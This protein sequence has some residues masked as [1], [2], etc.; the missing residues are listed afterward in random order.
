MTKRRAIQLVAGLCACAALALPASASAGLQTRVVGG[1]IAPAG[2]YPW[3]AAVM[4]DSAFGDTDYE[5]QFCGGV[6]VT[7]RIVLTA[8]HCVSDTDPDATH[9][10]GD[11]ILP[12]VGDPNGCFLDPNDA[13]VA[14]N[15]STLSAANGERHDIQAVFIHPDNNPSLYTDDV[16]YLV[17]S[18]AT[19]IPPLKLAGPS[20]TALWTPGRATQVTGYGTTAVGGGGAGSNNLKVA[21]VPILSDSTCSASYGSVFFAF[22]MV[23]AGYV[24]Q[25]V[26]DSCQGDSGGPLAAPAEGGIF[27]LVGLVSFGEGCANANKPGVYSRLGAGAPGTLFQGVVNAVADVESSQGIPHYDIVGSG[28]VPPGTKAPTSAKKKKCSKLKGKTKKATRKKRA[29]C[30]KQQRKQAQHRNVRR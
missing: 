5:G 11:C 13:D 30:R 14:L 4:L 29:R 20:E 6:L 23:C 26:A 22:S 19:G 25:G 28:A 12:P 18:S 16:A 1:G 9:S 15:E 2:A 3:Q 7:P 21:T 8:A 10:G 27:R 17:L 24:A